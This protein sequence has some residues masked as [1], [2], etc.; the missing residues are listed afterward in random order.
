MHGNVFSTMKNS[1]PVRFSRALASLA[2]GL[3]MPRRPGRYPRHLEERR[4]LP[5]G[6]AV[7]LR[8]IRPDDAKGL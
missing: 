8:P 2:G 1:T 4:R 5:D 3:G 6:T 7:F